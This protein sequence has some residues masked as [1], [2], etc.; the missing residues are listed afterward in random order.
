MDIHMEMKPKFNYKV[1]KQLFNKTMNLQNK[2][3]IDKQD[4]QVLGKLIFNQVNSN[5]LGSKYNDKRKAKKK[6]VGKAGETKTIESIEKKTIQLFNKT[7]Q[8]EFDKNNKEMEK[9]RFSKKKRK[10]LKIKPK[11]KPTQAENIYICNKAEK[12]NLIITSSSD[13][14]N[15]IFKELEVT[16]F[17]KYLK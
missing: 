2:Y 8:L 3:N 10:T 15:G 4:D 13:S 7:A 1:N 16:Y 14:L 17:K 11:K 12:E 6:K 5:H 9:R